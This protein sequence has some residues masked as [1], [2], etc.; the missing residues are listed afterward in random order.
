M[1]TVNQVANTVPQVPS[2]VV[3]PQLSQATV[4]QAAAQV[5]LT[6]VMF[7]NDGENKDNPFSFVR[8]YDAKVQGLENYRHAV[9]RY[10]NVD[11][12]GTVQRV[13]QMVTVPQM[14]LSDDLAIVLNKKE[15][16]VFLGLMEDAED[17]II[18]SQLDSGKSVIYWSDLGWIK[19]LD[20][21]T[22]E[23]VSQRL[24]KEQ[25]MAW[26]NV[27]MKEYCET[28]A[29]QICEAKG[30][31]GEDVSKQIAG[32]LTA[33]VDRMAKLAAPVPNLGQSEATALNNALLVSKLD[34]D[35]AK[36]LRAK[37]DQIL[38][39]KIAETGDL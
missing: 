9:I 10:R 32:T 3:I 23:R 20:F 38:H 6:M 36:V 26:A 14:K 29:K 30:L 35:M 1:E 24:T 4:T 19:A 28:R 13:A 33:Y 21:L 12:P 22:A 25:V 34:D 27:A 39:P 5:V 16:E 31:T 37:L 2:A 15:A 17:Q 18:R 8:G 11:K 7:R